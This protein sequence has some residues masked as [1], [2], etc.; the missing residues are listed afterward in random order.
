VSITA[1]LITFG[2][3]FFPALSRLSTGAREKLVKL[4]DRSIRVLVVCMLPLP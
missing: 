4:Y 2:G 1:G 3:A